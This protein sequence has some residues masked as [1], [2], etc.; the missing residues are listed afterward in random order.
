MMPLNSYINMLKLPVLEKLKKKDSYQIS[1]AVGWTE[2][3]R[4]SLLSCSSLRSPR[5]KCVYMLALA[6]SECGRRRID[7]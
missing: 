3:G 4:S 6:D 1:N 5:Q 2:V 7:E